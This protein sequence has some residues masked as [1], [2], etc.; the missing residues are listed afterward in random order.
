M[1]WWLVQIIEGL[2]RIT[3]RLTLI[4][5]VEGLGVDEHAHDDVANTTL[6]QVLQGNA[7]AESWFSHV[8]KL[9]LKIVDLIFCLDLLFQLLNNLTEEHVNN[10]SING[11]LV[12]DIKDSPEVLQTLG[13]FFILHREDKVKESFIVHFTF[14]SLEFFKHTINEDL[15]QTRRIPG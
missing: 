10:K 1:C 9:V 5:I 12:I 4:V 15:R 13:R 2:I 11:T 8:P 6:N 7:M 3:A 14:K